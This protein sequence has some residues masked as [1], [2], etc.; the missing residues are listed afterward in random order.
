[1]SG[2]IYLDAHATTAVDP[3]VLEYMMPWFGVA[4]NS[5]SD[6]ALGR[7]AAAAIERARAQVASLI[8][9]D[10]DEVVFTPGASLATNIALRSLAP[11]DS[12]AAR[13]AIEHSCVT[14][15]LSDLEPGVAVVELPV[16][17][18][19]LVEP[20]DVADALDQGASLVAVMAVN[21]EIGTIQPID[22]IGRL[23]DY[24]G[25]SLFVDLAQAAGRIPVDVHGSRISAAAVSSHKLYGPQGVGALF[26]RRDLI[27]KMRPVATGGGQERGLSPGTLPTAL[28]IGFGAACEVAERAMATDAAR[29]SALRDRLL[30]LLRASIS[31]LE[32]NG[33]LERRVANNLNVSFP[34][35]DADELLGSAPG[36]IAS[37]GSAC[38]SGA[39]AP[40]HVLTAM[41]LATDRVAGAIRFGLGRETTPDEID[42][43]AALVIQAHIALT[44]RK[45]A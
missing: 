6:H 44:G 30:E 28:C 9:A 21:N 18:E 7:N 45:S 39:I 26:C 41:G 24:A 15:T 25:A 5:H 14:E 37:T 42:R 17:I 3:A 11:P 16:G 31:G 32:V 2:P 36:L 34:G 20:D 12:T 1:M 23:C 27:M 35:I 4:A 40:S 19:G 10:Q 13:S 38:S 33:S 43:A 29:I 22:E 8:G